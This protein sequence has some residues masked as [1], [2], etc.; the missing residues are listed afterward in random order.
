M[1]G[2]EW[3]MSS[4]LYVGF[5]GW[6]PSKDLLTVVKLCR[7]FNRRRVY[8]IFDEYCGLTSDVLFKK[9]AKSWLYYEDGRVKGFALGRHSQGALRMRGAF[10]F[11]EVWAPCDGVSTEL[12]CLSEDDIE[13]VNR[14]RELIE[15]MEENLIVIRAS[16][17]NSFAHLVARTLKANWI[18]GLVLAERKL[19]EKVE[20]SVPKGFRLR[21]FKSG[22]E[23]RI[24]RI[25]KEVFGENFSPMRYRIWAT[26]SNCRTIVA[27]K[28]GFPVGF[29]IAEKRS[30][31]SLGDFIIAVDP[32]HHRKGLG[33]TLLQA[34]FNVFIDMNVKKVIADYLMLN[35]PAHHFYQ[36]HNFRPK[37]TYNYFLYGK[38]H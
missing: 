38:K 6:A 31:G 1:E 12:G 3:K 30:C 34:A 22:D 25:H 29:I 7:F 23:N 15:S 35:T 10:A 18:N 11:E 24:A 36:K 32:S 2:F 26:A 5:T 33:S 28:N 19:S 14:F 37:R 9:Q 8:A 13:K 4:N 20:V 17:D 27:T 21:T 16:V